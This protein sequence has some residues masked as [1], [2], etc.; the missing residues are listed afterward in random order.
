MYACAAWRKL[1]RAH[2]DRHPYCE[3]CADLGDV[4]PGTVV[5]HRTPHRGNWTLFLDDR[6]LQTL[7][8]THHDAVKQAFEKSGLLRGADA[9]GMPLDPAHPWYRKMQQL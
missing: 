9:D 5:D 4:V 3:M 8:S 2:L 1:R 6:N 7:C